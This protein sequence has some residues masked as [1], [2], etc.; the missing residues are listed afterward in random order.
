L[1]SYKDPIPGKT[2]VSPPIVPQVGPPRTL[3]IANRLIE[4]EHSYAQGTEQG[5]VVLRK[6]QGGKVEIQLKFWEVERELKIITLQSYNTSTDKPYNACISLR[7]D[8]IDQFLRMLRQVQRTKLS[9]SGTTTVRDSSIPLDEL[10][11]ADLREVV[12]SRGSEL[13][14]ILVDTV[15]ESDL[16][17]LGYR[18]SQL[19]YFDRLLNE[20]SFDKAE[21]KRLNKNNIE[22]VWQ[23]FFELNKWIFGY[24]LT[25]V[26]HDSLEDR[27]L[28]QIVSGHSIV[29]HGKR[30]DAVMASRAAISNVCLV[31]IKKPGTDLLDF[32]KSYR[33]GCWRVSQE[34]AGA[35]SQAQVTLDHAIHELQSPF[36]LQDDYGRPHGD[37]VF[38]YQPRCYLVVGTL[39]QFVVDGGINRDQVRSFELFRNSINRPHIITY[40]ELYERARLIVE[41]P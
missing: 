17:A 40:D 13:A 33:A 41:S 5:E 11:A 21:A 36:R 7:G 12:E 4:Q 25:L 35:V 28:E 8:E 19:A 22:S 32:T 18:R 34:L 38:V 1:D 31:E 6:T 30:S 14:D 29:K 26:W 10:T 16:V 3:R 23:N 24:S 15:T 39:G 27:K 37:D 2:Y 20:T 9:R